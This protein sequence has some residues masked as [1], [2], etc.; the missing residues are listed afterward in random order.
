MASIGTLATGIAHEINNPLAYVL[1]NIE[2]AV[3]ER[4]ALDD[5]VTRLR[6]TLS[7]EL[8][9]ERAEE[10][11]AEMEGPVERLE[12]HSH[13]ATEGAERPGDPGRPSAR[14]FR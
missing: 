11:L 12:R 1:L 4:N 2:A 13:D 8:G 14:R 9:R 5:R 3:R 10:L 7:E 6:E